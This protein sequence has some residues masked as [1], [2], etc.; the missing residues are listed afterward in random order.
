[1][2]SLCASGYYCSDSQ[3]KFWVYT[4]WDQ[5]KSTL[6]SRLAFKSI[7]RSVLKC[8]TL[9]QCVQ[10]MNKSNDLDYGDCTNQP[11]TPGHGSRGDFTSRGSRRKVKNHHEA[12]ELDLNWQTKAS[13]QKG[14]CILTFSKPNQTHRGKQTNPTQ[15]QPR[16]FK[17]N[18]TKP[19][20]LPLPEG[21]LPGSCPLVWRLRAEDPRAAPPRG[22]EGVSAGISMQP[23]RSLRCSSAA[24]NRT[25]DATAGERSCY[26][27]SDHTQSMPAGD[28]CSFL[29]LLEASPSEY[30]LLGGAVPAGR[31]AA[32]RLSSKLLTG[33][34]I[35]R[36]TNRVEL[37]AVYT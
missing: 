13:P 4:T 18:Q 17:K 28:A 29:L 20:E 19:K 27:R 11:W 6:S 24:R 23:V 35:G 22:A 36:F 37:R 32:G 16:G 33:V 7:R 31:D 5:V 10:L 25:R 21:A 12:P 26:G 14:Q 1:M 9:L 15:P 34:S 2:E 3:H 8:T 30:E